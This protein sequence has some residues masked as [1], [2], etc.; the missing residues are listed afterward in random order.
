MRWLHGWGSVGYNQCQSMKGLCTVFGILEVHKTNH[1][2]THAVIHHPLYSHLTRDRCLKGK[3]L[4]CLCVCATVQCIDL[5]LHGYS[6]SLFSSFV[7][8]QYSAVDSNPLSVYVMHPFWNFVV[9]VR[10]TRFS[11]GCVRLCG[12]YIINE[13][14]VPSAVIP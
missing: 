14:F 4:V 12:N 8:L 13:V 6:M 2:F 1:S 11:C 7:S 10:K 5:L 9:K 3:E